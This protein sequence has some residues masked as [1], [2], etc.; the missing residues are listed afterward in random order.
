M[1]GFDVWNNRFSSAEY[2][3]GEEPNAFLVRQK[4]HLP[5]AGRVLAV[6]DG[7]GRNGVWLAQQGLDVVSIDISPNAQE[8]A[9]TLA[10]KRGVP[11]TTELADL[12]AYSWPVSAYDAVVAIFI[13]FMGPA[14][15]AAAF[16]GMRRALKPGGLLLIEGYT[17]D[18]IALG[19]G[20]PKQAENM[21]TRAILET[22]FG[23]FY[24]VRIE[25]YEAEL[26]EGSGHSGRSALIDFV[27]EKRSY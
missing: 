18:Q 9:R 1:N 19:T 7:E 14:G 10:A 25:E 16:H 4:P 15:R 17:P 24:N 6:S 12:L 20:G 21:Y 13:Q 27:G 2:V 22:A 11:I 3:F 23:D 26:R 8:K 5:T